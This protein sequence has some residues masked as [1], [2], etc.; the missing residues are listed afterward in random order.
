MVLNAIACYIHKQSK[1]DFYDADWKCD[2]LPI[3]GF[4][5]YAFPCH[6][7]LLIIN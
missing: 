7:V 2:Y 6:S 3:Y 1:F 4:S 5:A